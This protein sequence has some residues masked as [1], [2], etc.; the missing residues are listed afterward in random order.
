MATQ[1]KSLFKD[2]HCLMKTILIVS[3]FK[4]FYWKLFNLD[5]EEE[6]VRKHFEDCGDIRNVRLIRDKKT[7][8]GK[9]FGY[10]NFQVSSSRLF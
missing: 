2:S 10:V 9:G 7:C 3:I 8:L 1:K 5:I 4:Y 6:P